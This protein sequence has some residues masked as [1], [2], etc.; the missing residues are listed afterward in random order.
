MTACR[1]ALAEVAW[2]SLDALA[3]LAFGYVLD[4][5][6]I[7]EGLHLHFTAAG[8]IKMMRRARRTRVLTYLS[9]DELLGYPANP[10]W[11]VVRQ[12]P[13]EPKPIFDSEP[14]RARKVRLYA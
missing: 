14:R 1:D 6:F 3:F 13:G 2:P 8:A 4:A 12:G 7:E 11:P 9:H 10:C 5:A